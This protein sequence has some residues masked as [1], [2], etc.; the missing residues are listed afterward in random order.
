MFITFTCRRWS[1]DFFDI[2]T[3]KENKLGRF[4]RRK[5]LFVVPVLDWPHFDLPPFCK[6]T[7]YMEK[8]KLVELLSLFISLN[9]IS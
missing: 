1:T 7:K 3:I 4:Q 5:L 6:S 9:L 8:V 2:D